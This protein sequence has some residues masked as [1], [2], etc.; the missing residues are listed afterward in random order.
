M[1]ATKTVDHVA[2]L[3]AE[4]GYLERRPET[5]RPSNLG[6]RGRLLFVPMLNENKLIGVFAVAT[7]KKSVLHRQTDRNW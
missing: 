5:L 7:V 3:A 6:V 1:I 4:Q 2:D